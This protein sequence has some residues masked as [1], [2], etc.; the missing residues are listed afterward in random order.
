MDMS[1]P[2]PAS[3]GEWLAASSAAVTVLIGLF[4][5]FAPRLRLRILGLALAADGR[6]GLGAARG[7]LAGFPLGIGLASLILAQPFVYMALG[8]SWAFA[9][10]GRL[11][12]ILSDGGNGVGNWTMLLAEVVLAFLPLFFVF[13]PVS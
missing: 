7:S 1:M 8:L 11:I 6:L 5:L 10:F 9:A 4:S 3:Q 12:S 13:A 2:W